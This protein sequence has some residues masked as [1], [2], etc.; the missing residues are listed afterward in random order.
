M[1][2]RDFIYIKDIVKVLYHFY[3]NTNKASGLYNVGTGEA[4]T[5]KDLAE[6][7]FQAMGLEPNISY[8]DTPKDIRKN[9]QYFTEADISKLRKAGYRSK[10]QTL[11]AGIAD[12][13]KKYLVG[14]KIY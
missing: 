5:F 4:R 2:A 1:Q 12:Y 14:R 9:Y 6:N 7:T 8:I 10:F 11:E 3:K 13:V